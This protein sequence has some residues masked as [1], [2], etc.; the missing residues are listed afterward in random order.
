MF[1]RSVDSLK[2]DA[3]APSPSASP[4]MQNTIIAKGVIVEGDFKSDGDVTIEGEVKGTLKING[5]LIIGSEALVSGTIEAKD[6]LLAGT[7]DGPI[8]VNGDL[9]LQATAKVKGDVKCHI[10]AIQRGAKV[11]GKIQMQNGTSN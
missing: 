10:L 7:I 6:A 5:R 11:E 8:M 1:A 3:S 2:N 9:E 4:R